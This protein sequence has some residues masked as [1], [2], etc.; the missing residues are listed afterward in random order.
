MAH[1][2]E[3]RA[4]ART[5]IAAAGR[6]RWSDWQ[7]VSTIAT[8]VGCGL[9]QAQRLARDWKLADACD[10]LARLDARTTVQQLSLWET[11]K[12]R[13]SPE[14]LDALCRLYETRPDRLGFGRDY[15]PTEEDETVRVTPSPTTP[16]ADPA[17]ADI[18]ASGTPTLAA[19]RESMTALFA[20]PLAETTLDQWERQ[21]AEYGLA[22]QIRPPAELL[23]ESVHDCLQVRA[24]LTQRLPADTRVRLCRIAAQLAGTAGIALVALGEHREA[25]KWY[26]LGQLAAEETVDRTLR[27]WLLAREAVIPFYFGAPAAALSLAERARLLAGNTA[28]ATAAWAPSLEARAL[29]LMGRE[30]DARTAMALAETA[31]GRLSA[32]ETS[33]TAYGYTARQLAWH[34]GSMWTTLGDTRSAQRSLQSAREQYAQTEH[35]DRAL[36][37]IDGV[38][39][40]RRR[41]QHR[42][43]RDRDPADRAPGRAPD[44][45]RDLPRED[46]PRER[47]HAHPGELGRARPDR[48][49]AR[50][51]PPRAARAVDL[52]VSGARGVAADP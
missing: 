1:A 29:A 46:P 52:A 5:L 50:R 36:I 41:G 37:D 11:G 43:P 31:F 33:D 3:A 35:L 51:G 8:E 2:H 49:G 27:A 25:R 16:S 7:L 18:A 38:S 39:H 26:H 32:A 21:A 17:E 24:V 6:D 42:L 34:M 47:P 13:P 9:L 30:R 22:Y 15:T 23:A 4:A 48:A 20:A 44:R 45:D 19:V 14:K 28:C 40:A 10:A 12:G